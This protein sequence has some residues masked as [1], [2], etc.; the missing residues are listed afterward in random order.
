MPR[1]ERNALLG[2]AALVLTAL[3][4]DQTA[5]LCNGL[6]HLVPFFALVAPLLFGRYLGEHVLM[7]LRGTRR[8]PAVSRPARLRPAVRRVQV[9]SPHLLA[10][11]FGRPPPITA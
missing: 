7:R 3:L 5:G 9:A 10:G 8:R 6:L 1:R 2:L 11:H 4:A